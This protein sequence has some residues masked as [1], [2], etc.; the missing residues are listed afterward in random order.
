[1]SYRTNLLG[2]RSATYCGFLLMAILLC[3]A[4]SAVADPAPAA[5]SFQE[6]E[7]WNIFINTDFGPPPPSLPVLKY[8]LTIGSGAYLKW[9]GNIY[10]IEK[11]WAFY[12][13]NKSGS[14]ANDMDASGPA[15]GQWKWDTHSRA[16][17]LDVAGWIN[18][19][20]AEA[21]MP[22][23][24]AKEFQYDTLVFRGQTLPKLGIHVQVTLQGAPSPFG[25]GGG[26]TGGIIPIDIVPEPG[27]LSI[28]ASGLLLGVGGL[29]KHRLSKKR[30]I[31]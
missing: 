13:V 28:L 15:I 14:A 6:M 8:E 17:H 24:P 3:F 25:E 9:N 23:D 7:T 1:M 27:S 19:G 22:G 30:R 2:I 26:N 4:M 5:A 20:H 16:G 31:V 21:I 18:N 29:A 12:A 10:P 11:C